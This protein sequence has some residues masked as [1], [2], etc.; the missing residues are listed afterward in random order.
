MLRRNGHLEVWFGAKAQSRAAAQA[1]AMASLEIST[2]PAAD[3]L[4]QAVARARGGLRG[5]L[6]AGLWFT[7]TGHV[8]DP[9]EIVQAFVNTALQRGAEFKR[10][11]VKA[12]EPRAGGVDIHT[13][14]ESLS[15]GSVVV[16][17][18]AW[19]ASLLE[20]LGLRVPMQ[21]AR[22]YH[23]ELPAHHAFADAPIVYADSR[24]LVTP[25]K[26]RLRA[27]SFMEFAAPDAQPDARKPARLRAMLVELG[28][29]CPSEG[30][31]W[32]GPRPVLPDYLPGIGRL[33]HTSV[34]YAT[35]HQHIGLTMAPVTG[36]LI[37]D[38]L[39]GRPPRH[40]ISA[41]DLC[42][43]GPLRKPRI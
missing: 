27:S 3:E 21:A 17:T 16:C 15:V 5:R 24:L 1:L 43:F 31:S 19:S 32:V 23:V 4:L 40:D 8:L 22:G 38:L 36:E 28:Y 26:G 14:A 11:D 41:F 12:L 10:A 33:E 30:P 25:M 9:L 6:V 34:Y 29:E 35:G 2:Q 39:A 7:S 37:A 13:S 18:G 42:R 20:P